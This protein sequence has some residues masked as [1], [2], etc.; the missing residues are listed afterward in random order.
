MIKTNMMKYKYI[1]MKMKKKKNFVRKFD[2]EPLWAFEDLC[3][4]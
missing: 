3:I 1:C 2:V 4:Y